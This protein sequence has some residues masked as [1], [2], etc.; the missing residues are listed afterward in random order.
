V[1]VTKE[2]TENCQAFLN[3]EMEPEEVELA[4]KE[5]YSR[6]VK[7]TTVPGFRKGKAPRDMLERYIGKESMMEDAFNHLLPDAYD[8]AIKEQEITP[9]GQPV[10]ELLNKEPVIFKA[11]VPLPPV[12]KL[13]D[14]HSIRVEAEPATVGEEDINKVVEQLQHQNASWES[15]EQAVEYGNMVLMDVDST[16]EGETF[17]KQDNAQYQV[18]EDA[19]YPVIGFSEQLHGMNKNEVKE[20][21]IKM[22]DDY[23]KP[24]VA[25]KE[26]V[27]KITIK[28]IK[29]ETLPELDDELA[30]K[31]S[32]ESESFDSFRKQIGESVKARNESKA[33]AEYEEKVIA[34]IAAISEVEYPPL[35]VDMEIDHALKEQLQ[36]MQEKGTSMEEYLQNINKTEEQLREDMKPAAEK[37]VSSSLLFSKIVDEEK[38]EVT[39]VEIDEHIEEMIKSAGEN[40]DQMR[41][42]MNN[43]QTKE[44]IKQMLITQNTMKK[45]VEIAGGTNIQEKEEEQK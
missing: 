31:I 8:K 4:L 16:V 20:F 36:H 35:L 29:K 38:T 24:E 2:K 43:P 33:K 39:H 17:I 23:M 19:D 11:T 6:L 28:D 45:L 27:F 3:V 5:S 18:V 10:L 42:F 44:S 41:A 25:G 32:P 37:R 34:A 1:K 26:A 15:I 21:T 13:G 14:Y 22:S 7:K 30:K 12:V 9:I 40:K